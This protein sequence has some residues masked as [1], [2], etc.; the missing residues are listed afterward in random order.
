VVVTL[1]EDRRRVLRA[2]LPIWRKNAWVYA[3]KVDGVVRGASAPRRMLPKEHSRKTNA[4]L[5]ALTLTN[6]S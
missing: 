6:Q 2:R 1:P 5:T 3:I 4:V